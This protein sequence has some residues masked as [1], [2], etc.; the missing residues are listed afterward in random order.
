MADLGLYRVTVVMQFTRRACM[1]DQDS[2]AKAFELIASLESHI[3]ALEKVAG[4]EKEIAACREAIGH[5][6]QLLTD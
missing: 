6:K 4:R 1:T 5:L 2:R 3:Q